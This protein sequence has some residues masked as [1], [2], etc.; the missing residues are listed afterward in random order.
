MI[1]GMANDGKILGIKILANSESADQANKIQSKSFLDKFLFNSDPQSVDSVDT[2][3]QA[4][5]SSKAVKNGV[6]CALEA[7]KAFAEGD[8]K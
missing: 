7:Y 8:A 6:K 1:V 5:F 3:S 2:L 4:T